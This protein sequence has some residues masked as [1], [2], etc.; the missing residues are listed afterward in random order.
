M[1]NKTTSMA[2]TLNW[3][4]NTNKQNINQCEFLGMA[5]FMHNSSNNSI[6]MFSSVENSKKYMVNSKVYGIASGNG[7][8]N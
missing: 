5:W 8:C 3:H 4:L 7:S 6:H 2:S 1:S